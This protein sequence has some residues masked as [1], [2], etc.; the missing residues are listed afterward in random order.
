[1]AVRAAE[2]AAEA[3][4]PPAKTDHPAATVVRAE[5]V[6]KAGLAAMVER[7]SRPTPCLVSAS[8][9]TT[10]EAHSPLA[11]P[12]LPVRLVHPVKEALAVEAVVVEEVRS[13]AL[14]VALL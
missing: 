9:W 5:R 14:R 6:A 3:G 2:G 8:W 4:R 11:H 10:L 1:M 12:G 13:N 7:P